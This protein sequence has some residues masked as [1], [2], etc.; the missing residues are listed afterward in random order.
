MEFKIKKNE[1]TYVVVKCSIPFRKKAK[2]K[3]THVDPVDAEVYLSQQGIKVT[4]CKSNTVLNNYSSNIVLEGEW[5]FEKAQVKE[6]GFVT[7]ETKEIPDKQEA[8][9]ETIEEPKPKK[10]TPSRTTSKRRRA[11]KQKR[12]LSTEEKDKLFGA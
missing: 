11:P 5:E 4:N 12:E 7:K 9:S 10:P 8:E 1:E 6:A 2:D 3:R